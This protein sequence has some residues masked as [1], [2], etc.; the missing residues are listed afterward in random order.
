MKIYSA[1]S[2]YAYQ[3]SYSGQRPLA[4]AKG[5]EF[6]FSA[7]ADRK[8]WFDVSVR[9][10][11]PAVH[12]WESEHGRTLSASEWYALAKM[13]LFAAFDER[14]T[15]AAMRASPVR[16]RQADVAAILEQLGRE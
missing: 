4:A 5:A 12:A 10:E 13:A 7:S 8:T 2:G 3:Y 9:I 14:A 16:L 11:A 6:V 1:Q 15:P